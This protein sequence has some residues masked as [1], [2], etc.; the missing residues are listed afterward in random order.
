MWKHLSLRS[1]IFIILAALAVTTL[2]GGLIT[3]WHTEATDALLSSLVDQNLASFRA[4]GEVEKSL[5]LQ[6]G[7]LTYYFLDS[8]PD[9]L[10][11][12]EN[13]H[14]KF[15]QELAGARRLAA[16]E[17]MKDI[18]KQI[19]ANYQAYLM[20]R[21]RVI[22]HYQSGE[23]EAGSRLHQEVRRQFGAIR[24]LCE[25]YKLI[26][27][28]SISRARTESQSH[29]RF[30]N[31]MALTG[32]L[33][34]VGLGL[35]LVYILFKQILGPIRRL[36]L[37]ADPR[38]GPPEEGNEVTALSQRLHHLM[39][40]VDQAQSQLERSQET[41]V[42]AGKMALVGKL[43]AGVAHSIRNPLTS[44]KMR[45]F[46]LQRALALT[47]TQ[48]EDLEVISE[49]IRHIDTIVRHF[50]E[51]SRPPKL[52]MQRVSLS[53]VVDSALTLLGQRLESYGVRVELH[54]PE[55]LPP[56]WADPEQLKEVLVN[57]LLNACDAMSG[58]GVITIREAR[59]QVAPVGPV[60]FLSLSD[61][62]PGVPASIRDKIF[63]PFF[64]SKEEGAGLGLSIASRI[65]EE[66][67]GWIE[68]QAR[69]GEGATFIITLPLREE[70]RWAPSS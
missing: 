29:A 10:S 41:L 25:R 19:E 23:R 43:A 35:L 64:S 4:A 54:R 49:E 22:E 8:N 68:L 1:R 61:T 18:L 58:G 67:G 3:I 56:T 32:M 17:V 21:Q 7:Y 62:G 26:H 52:K 53:D 50:L 5:L 48:K 27:E 34:V 31:V 37:D 11:Q 33:I 2:G 30:I 60:A 28:Y 66:H 44:V 45:L 6:K 38:G 70:E 55:R 12:L 57:L 47:P 14:Q 63:Q 42:Q 51:F 24:D 40:D 36:A 39:E 46:S 65:V 9:W 15:L 69:E 20:A 59:G 13:H 16:N